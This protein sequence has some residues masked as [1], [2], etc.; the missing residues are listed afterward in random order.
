MERR[1]GRRRWVPRI[2]GSH[3]P[4]RPVARRQLLA[5]RPLLPARPRVRG[6]PPLPPR[7]PTLRRRPTSQARSV[8]R[9]ATASG[10]RPASRLAHPMPPRT[11]RPRTTR[12]RIARAGRAR[13]PRAP[14]PRSPRV[15][16]AWRLEAGRFQ[17]RR[18]TRTHPRAP[19]RGRRSRPAKGPGRQVWRV[20]GDPWTARTR[21]RRIVGPGRTRTRGTVGPGRGRWGARGRRR[22]ERLPRLSRNG[23]PGRG[24]GYRP[25]VVRSATG[26]GRQPRPTR[27]RLVHHPGRP[28]TGSAPSRAAT[29]R[30]V[31]SGRASPELRPLQIGPPPR[32]GRPATSPPTQAAPRSHRRAH[33]PRPT[34]RTADRLGR[35][36]VKGSRS[37][38]PPG[39]WRGLPGSRSTTRGVQTPRPLGPGERPWRPTGGRTPRST[40]PST[41]RPAR[42]R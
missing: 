35:R 23:A 1:H 3:R 2:P 21:T 4:R 29:A 25:A 32:P 12:P 14:R 42:H 13:S 40:P 17:R 8:R 18:W 16:R 36:V 5:M 39:A 24:R 33:R 7:P 37:R 6:Y 28:A 20:A 38:G 11:R 30:L 22:L 10:R 41:G 15:V 34:T 26:P 31:A 9:R 19:P 27:Y